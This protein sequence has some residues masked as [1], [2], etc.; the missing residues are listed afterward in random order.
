MKIAIIG[1]GFSS[2]S[3]ACYLAKQGHKVEV[4][5]KNDQ[6]GGR[7]RTKKIDGYTFDM[8]PSW[9][10]MPDVFENFFAD[11]GKK[12][13]DF[14]D[15]R[16]I[17]PSYRV[18][19][20]DAPDDIP[21]DMVELKA[22][23]EQYEAGAGQKLEQF[24]QEA[25]MKY[26]VGMGDFVTKPS[27]SFTEFLSL[28]TA[29]KG[30]SL[31]LFKPISKHIRQFFKHPKLIELLEFPVLFLGAKPQNTPSLYSLMNYADMALGTWYPMGGMNKIVEGMV[32]VASELGV[33]FHTSANVAEIT[34]EG[35]KVTGIKSNN[36]FHTADVVV[37]GA[38]Y[39]HTEQKLLAPQYRNY[40]E[41]Y[42]DKRVMA[43]SSLLYYVGLDTKVDGIKHH[44]LF[45]DESF[46]KHA[47][48]I[49]DTHKWPEAPLFYICNPSKTDHSVA[50][51]GKENMFFLVP[52]STELKDSE[53]SRK[54]YFDMICDRLQKHIG[55]DIRPHIEVYE[56]FAHS[57]F[58]SEYNSFKGNAYG[59]AN[60]LR[61]TALLKPKCKNKKL[62][63]LY[64][65][66]QLT[67]PGPGVPPSIISG[68]IVSALIQQEQHKHESII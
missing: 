64:Y 67:V 50:P 23:F 35:R 7:A 18:F 11:F 15:L 41:K 57:D 17:D 37:S 5:E 66:G 9:Y 19:W 49:Y 54:R 27:L 40:D 61:Q 32:S 60:T 4:F 24:L 39:H 14:Y 31:D 21:A 1:S 3:N 44:N 20:P 58:M 28:N 59:L 55:K 63:N 22:Y 68:K 29:R 25:K 8:G 48:E 10:W 34:A 42:W 43:P 62:D 52:V 16:R 47:I 53:S 6:L 2:L 36:V 30:I 46:D 45:F 26:E 33:K 12:V 13:S 51:E 38:D 56:D 65:I